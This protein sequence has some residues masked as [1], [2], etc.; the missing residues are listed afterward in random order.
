MIFY[1]VE[2]FLRNWELRT[3]RKLNAKNLW[4]SKIYGR[5]FCC[6]ILCL[7]LFSSSIVFRKILEYFSRVL[8]VLEYPQILNLWYKNIIKYEKQKITGFLVVFLQ[9]TKKRKF[10]SL[11]SFWI[12]NSVF[13]PVRGRYL[14]YYRAMICSNLKSLKPRFTQILHNLK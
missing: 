13:F 2:D 3:L 1:E 6:S 7:W 14:I 9:K 12:F 10:L 5:S 4:V 8:N 11:V